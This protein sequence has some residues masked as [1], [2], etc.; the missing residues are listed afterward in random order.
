MSVAGA[1]VGLA[2]ALAG[3]YQLVRELGRGGMGIV[4]LARERSLDRD[5]ALKVLP[6]DLATRA[7]L[8]ERFLREARTAAQLSHPHIVPI[9]SADESGGFAWFAMGFVDG[10][11]LAQRIA[12]R[13]RLGPAETVRVLREAAWALAYAHARGIVHRDVKPE[14]VML[15]RGT[16]RVMV[17]DFGIA[18]Q[19]ADPSLTADGMVLGSVH[20]MSPEQVS[21][22]ALDGRSDLYALGVIGFRLLAGRLPFEDA[23]PS[24]VLVAHATR[25]APSLGGMAPDVPR[26][27]AAVIDR[28]L[29]KDPAQRFA[30]GEQL[31]DALTAALEAAPPSD[32]AAATPI[33]QVLSTEQA[34]AIW[35]RAA[36]LQMDA[37]TAIRKRPPT[38]GATGAAAAPTDGYRLQ[39]VEQAA[40][41]VGIAKEFVQ[42]ALA[43]LPVQ[44][45]D[46]VPASDAEEAQLTRV[47]GTDQRSLRVAKVIEAPI[48]RVLELLGEVV[49]SPGYGLQL[50]DTIGGHPLDGG[51]MSFR[52]AGTMVSPA[53][54][55]NLFIYRM[56]QLELRQIS[57]A[58]HAL[59][60]TPERTEVVI[61]GDLRPGA[62]ANFKWSHRVAR[63]V[64]GGVAVVGGGAAA[65][66]GALATAVVLGAGGL[67][68]GLA[69]MGVCYA[70]WRAAYRGALKGATEELEKLLEQVNADLRSHAVFGRPALPPRRPEGGDDGGGAALGALLGGLRAGGRR[71]R[72]ALA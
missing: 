13:G 11:T 55:V 15:E 28:C 22:G 23:V 70:G 35:L 66:K 33:P 51:V 58:L 36:Q 67:A 27:L 24:A 25:P 41:E 71:G 64:G 49:R 52:I 12:A 7:D 44:R 43:E 40:A 42:L 62:R 16:G 38:A 69:L 30:T 26:P 4:F 19:A 72:A 8:R 65:A 5:V 14:N 63:W 61:T 37:A 6:P 1:P 47:L 20:Y 68:A 21:G 2:E 46:A 45:A 53:G 32:P 17:A 56:E 18:R 39:D 9:H 59:P 3:R 48:A 57:I 10:E 34:E 60:G 50:L 29:A 31:A 54:Q